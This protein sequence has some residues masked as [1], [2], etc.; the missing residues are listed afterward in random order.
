MKQILQTNEQQD[1]YSAVWYR[2]LSLTERAI[3]LPD[4]SQDVSTATAGSQSEMARKRFQRWQEQSPF[5]RADYF[6]QRL[7]SAT[8]TEEDLLNLLAET[9]EALQARLAKATS[10]PW[11]ATLIDTFKR[12]R[13][14]QSLLQAFKLKQRPNNTGHFW[15]P[16]N[17]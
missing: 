6:S 14:E 17:L 4:N 15:I 5:S 8:L 2:A 3:L 11:L 9:P 12:Y 16:L 10:L 1:S 13:P 7:A